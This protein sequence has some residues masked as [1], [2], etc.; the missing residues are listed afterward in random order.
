MKRSKAYRIKQKERVI[1]NRKTL[2]KN[3]T[4]YPPT[5]MV[6]EPNRMSKRHPLDCGVAGCPLCHHE[7]NGLGKSYH[8]LKEES[9]KEL[10]L[11]DISEELLDD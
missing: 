1:K 3:V 10:L 8:D 5:K 11:E 7:K 9:D 6:E 4:N 2:L